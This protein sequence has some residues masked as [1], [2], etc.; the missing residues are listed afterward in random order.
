MQ[1]PGPS[2]EQPGPSQEQPGTSQ[3]QPGPSQEQA[4]PSRQQPGPSQEQPGPSQEQAPSSRQQPGP[5]QEQPGPSQEQVPSSRQQPGPSQE[6][7]G[8]SQEQPGPSSR[9]QIKRK[10]SKV[11]DLS[12]ANAIVK[13]FE[14]SKKKVSNYRK[15]SYS[16]EIIKFSLTLQGYSTKG[17]NYVRKT[18]NDALPS[19][20]NSTLKRHLAKLDATPG[21][22]NPALHL[23]QGRVEEGKLNN[24]KT[25]LSLS[26]DEISIRKA[27]IIIIC[28]SIMVEE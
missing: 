3:A 28:T 9:Q 16:D 19:N 15:E 18:F 7:P 25:Y 8:P 2:Q 23:L 26:M 13:E 20:F 14:Q 10:I 1:Q 4:P 11:D 27:T 5:S 17:Y 24:K 12:T 22:S 21:I 6:Q